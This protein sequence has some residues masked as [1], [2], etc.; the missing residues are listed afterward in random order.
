MGLWEAGLYPAFQALARQI[1]S[2]AFGIHLSMQLP[3]LGFV[4]GKQLRLHQLRKIM[5]ALVSP[6]TRI[7][8]LPRDVRR[9]RHSMA[10]NDGCEL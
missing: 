10:A 8:A 4:P 5:T 6:R 2:L 9:V 3:R 1:H 7:Q